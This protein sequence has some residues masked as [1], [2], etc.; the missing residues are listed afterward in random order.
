MGI[1]KNFV[2]RNGLE[3]DTDLIFADADTN[4]VGIGSTIPNCKLSVNGNICGDDANFSG[5]VTASTFSGIVSSTSGSFDVLELGDLIVSGGSSLSGVTT[6]TQLEVSGDTTLGGGLTVTGVSTFASNVDVNASLDVQNDLS[7]TGVSTFA[8]NVD[9]NA[10]LDVQDDLIV[11][12]GLTV[13]GVS[14]FASNVDVNASLDVQNDLSVTGLSTFSSNVDVNASVDIQNDLSVTGV[15]TFTS[16]VD[17]NASLDIQDDLTINNNLSVTG[18]STFSSNV[19]VNASVDIQNDLSVTGLST[20]AS[21]VDVNASL[22]VQNDVIIGGGLT[23]TGVSTIASNVD[24][25]G[26][27]TASTLAVEDLTDNRIVIVGSGGELEDDANLT[28]DGSQLIVGTGLS[29]TGFSTFSNIQIT[30]YLNDGNSS[31]VSGQYLKSTGTGVTWA[32]FQSTAV[33]TTT[34]TATESQ[35]TFTGLTYTVGLIDVYLNGVRLTPSEFT[36]TN[37]T[38]VTLDDGAFEGDTLDFVTYSTITDYGNVENYWVQTDVGIHTLSNVGIGTTNP[39]SKLTVDGSINVTGIITATEGFISVGNTTP[40]QISLVGNQLTF[41][42]AGIGS[43][44]FTLS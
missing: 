26:G 38:S 25:N 10:S 5:I 15:S 16:N 37:G 4:K 21:N 29:V 20:F 24:V 13:T 28:Y 23:V 3:V 39:T 36:A 12:G 18:L 1:N 11:G 31:G 42:A 33:E 9:V 27:I 7:V 6:I 44:T 32:T 2:I 14:T 34:Q 8:S 35:T 40:I 43:T 19:D 30:G 17:I 22:D 41:T